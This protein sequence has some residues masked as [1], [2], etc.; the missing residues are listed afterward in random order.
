MSRVVENLPKIRT[1]LQFCCPRHRQQTNKQV[2]TS[3]EPWSGRPPG[4]ERC[5]NIAGARRRVH[6][7]APHIQDWLCYC[8]RR[9]IFL[10]LLARERVLWAGRLRVV[11]CRPRCVSLN[12]STDRPLLNLLPAVKLPTKT[13]TYQQ[14]S[15][16]PKE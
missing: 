11:A 10:L 15:N 9:P 8:V 6:C 1:R 3:Q 12:G 4:G 16:V 7:I 13:N 5:A 14:Q 2:N